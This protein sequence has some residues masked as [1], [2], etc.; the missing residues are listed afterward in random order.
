LSPLAQRE[1]GQGLGVDLGA[2]DEGK[3]AVL[4]AD[5]QPDLGARQHDGLGTLL[6][7][8]SDRLEVRLA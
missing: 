3:R 8:L 6:R 4:G 7:H 5:Q 2:V 1:P